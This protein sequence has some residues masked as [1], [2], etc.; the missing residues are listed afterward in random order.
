M[1]DEIGGL[2]TV[3]DA[4]ERP[5]LRLLHGKY[6]SVRVAVLR[7]LF[8]SERRAIPTDLLH[9]RVGAL[10]DTFRENGIDT[11]D[12][13]GRDLCLS[14]MRGK[15]LQRLSAEDRAGEVYE[16][17]AAAVDALRIVA[18]LSSDRVLVSESRLTTHCD[19]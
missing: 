12:G 4:F 5:T 9:V 19:R 18:D 14:W 3:E 16:L 8:D 17:T 15:W 10:I 11:P 13:T 6:A 7:S 1:N 2:R